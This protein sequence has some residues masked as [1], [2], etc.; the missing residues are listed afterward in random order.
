MVLKRFGRNKGLFLIGLL[1]LGLITQ[2]VC[3]GESSVIELS[4]GS[5]ITGEVVSFDGKVWTIQSSSM[6]TLKIDGAKIVSIRSKTAVGKEPDGGISTG[7]QANAA[8]MQA[9]QQSIMA[10]EQIMA[11]IMG[12]QHEPEIQAILQDPE[13]MQA[14][15][16]GD[17]HALL[18]NPKFIRL[19]ENAKIKDITKEAVK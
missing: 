10:N 7:S 3:A 19:M 9:M 12:L 15:N 16:A 11:M 13:V 8:D 4:D 14:V 17:M 2:D 5:V 18:S 1:L 6:G